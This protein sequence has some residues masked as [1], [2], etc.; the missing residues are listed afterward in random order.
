M[1]SKGYQFEEH[2]I[3]TS[4]GYILTAF[5]IPGKLSGFD[6]TLQ[7]SSQKYP[8]YMQH[9]LIDDGGTWFFDNQ[10][11]DLSLQLA[12]M[13][14][15]IWVTN[16]RGTCYSNAHMNYTVKDKEFW[17][18]TLHDMGLNDVPANLNYILTYTGA[19]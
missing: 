7:T 17:N 12:D 18:F 8:V 1:T 11:L 14:Y 3:V 13:G 5:R 19:S 16:S 4:D 9:G 15:D 10:T 2:N 6:D